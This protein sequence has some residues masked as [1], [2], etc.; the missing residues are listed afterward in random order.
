M[1]FLIL[2]RYNSFYNFF[3]ISLKGKIA[4]MTPFQ[5]FLIGTAIVGIVLYYLLQNSPL[6]N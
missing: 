1:A 3:D 2:T 4:M 6:V 5:H